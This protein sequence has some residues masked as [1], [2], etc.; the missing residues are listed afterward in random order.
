MNKAKQLLTAV[1]ADDT[2]TRHR[3][4][5]ANELIA[6]IATLDTT[7]ALSKKRITTAV[8][9]SGTSLCDIYGV[10][11]IGAAQIIGYVGDITRF[12]TKARFAAY[13]G[14]APVEA[15]SGG[16]TRHRLNQRG[17]RKLNHAIHIAAVTQFRNQSEGRIFYD[18]KISEGKPTKKPSAH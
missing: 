7:L 10:G 5:I 12:E 17:N 8:T 16:R 11:P 14:T 4:L 2:P 6:D 15:S 18:R 3:L 1:P 9:A 13:N